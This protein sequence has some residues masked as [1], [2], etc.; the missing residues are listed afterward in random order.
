LRDICFFFFCCIFYFFFVFFSFSK[1]A[2]LE[3]TRVLQGEKKNKSEATPK[4]KAVMN[5]LTSSA[6]K[7]MN[8]PSTPGH[9]NNGL[10]ASNGATNRIL[11][12]F[13]SPAKGNNTTTNAENS[14]AQTMNDKLN[15]AVYHF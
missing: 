5:A 11:T 4:R 13:G 9:H 2:I 6:K 3:M 10:Q 12:F 14:V 15:H 7:F 1:A 8:S